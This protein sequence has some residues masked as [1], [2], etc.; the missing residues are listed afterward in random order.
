MILKVINKFSNKIN[1]NEIGNKDYSTKNRNSGLGLNYISKI[2][3][4]NIKTN[5]QIV[6]NLFIASIEYEIKENKK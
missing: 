5:I 2:K 3:N 4:K 1:L 6:N